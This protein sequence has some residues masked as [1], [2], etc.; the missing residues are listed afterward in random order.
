[1]TSQG[2]KIPKREIPEGALIT[3][4]ILKAVMVA[5]EKEFDKKLAKVVNYCTFSADLGVG[6]LADII[7][8]LEERVECLE[9]P[10]RY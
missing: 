2:G 6:K 3:A 4:D 1:M 10:R 5:Q 8:K 9:R 7:G